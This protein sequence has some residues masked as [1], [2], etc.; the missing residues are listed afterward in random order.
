MPLA[1]DFFQ[2][3][4]A[5]LGVDFGGGDAVVAQEFLYVADVHAGFQEVGGG[6][7]AQ[8]VGGDV[9]FQGGFFG[10]AGDEFAQELRGGGFAGG[11]DEQVFAAGIAAAA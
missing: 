9:A 5:D 8:H 1:D 2:A 10:G 6:A 3:V 4:V 11:G 7:V